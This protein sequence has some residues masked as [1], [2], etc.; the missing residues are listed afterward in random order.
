[1]FF[2]KEFESQKLFEKSFYIP[3]EQMME[4]NFLWLS[5]N[6]LKISLNG[7]LPGQKLSR[8]EY[9]GFGGY[10]ALRM[11]EKV[12]ER[13]GEMK[14]AGIERWKPLALM[15]RPPH[16][17]ERSL[18]LDRCIC[19]PMKFRSYFN[20]FFVFNYFLYFYCFRFVLWTNINSHFPCI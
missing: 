11:E 17:E 20:L 19:L 7:K 13:I 8:H 2:E 15:G 3:H 5:C 10:G 4:I 16:L 6:N 14:V 1:M 9:L 12:K 18:A